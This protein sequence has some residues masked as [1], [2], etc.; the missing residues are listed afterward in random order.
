M[1]QPQNTDLFIQLNIDTYVPIKQRHT[2]TNKSFY[3]TD[4]FLQLNIDSYVP[5]QQIHTRTLRLLHVETIEHRHILKTK[6]QLVCTNPT[7]TH[8]YQ[9]EQRHIHTTKHRHICTNQT[10]THTYQQ[11]L[12]QNTDIFL[13]LNINSYVPT[14]QIHTRTL[15]LLH[16]PTTEHRHILKTKHKLVCTNPTNTHSY[17]SDH[18]HTHTTKLSIDSYP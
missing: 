7:N 9:S 5:T 3:R 8:T 16:V 18:R 6:H 10:E 14:Q 1:Y 4:I 17:Q 15:R 12:S 13:Q 11:I 2:R